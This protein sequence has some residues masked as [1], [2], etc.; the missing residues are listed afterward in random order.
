[1]EVEPKYHRHF[2][3]RRGEVLRQIGE[4]YGGVIVSFPR[5]GT[6]SSKVVL[7]GAND[8]VQGAKKRIMEI[9]DDLVSAVFALTSVSLEHLVSCVDVM[10]SPGMDGRGK[11][12]RDYKIRFY[13]I[14]RTIRSHAAKLKSKRLPPNPSPP[15]LKH[16]PYQTHNHSGRFCFTVRFF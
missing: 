5:N 3:A 13:I 1:M 4:D 8:C 7:K 11:N 16:H 12:G 2:V 9:V 10:F 14:Y 15:V 6:N